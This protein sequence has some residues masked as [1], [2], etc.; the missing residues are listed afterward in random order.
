MKRNARRLQAGLNLLEVLIATLVLSVGLLGLAGLQVS[1]LKTTQNASLKQ[2]ATFILYD[3]LERMRSNR[4][5]VLA[6]SYSKTT[7]CTSAPPQVCTTANCSAAQLA[8]YELYQV[9]CRSG[10]N[11]LPA[12]QLTIHCPNSGNCGLGLHFRLTWDERLAQRGI[13]QASDNNKSSVEQEKETISLE[14]DAI[15]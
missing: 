13:Q 7:H 14:M 1:S 15:L 3:L 12:A 10:T 5:A 6:G 4:Q 9:V 8:S 11:R 2:E